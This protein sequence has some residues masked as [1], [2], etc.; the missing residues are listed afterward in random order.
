VVQLARRIFHSTGGG[1]KQIGDKIM[2]F[3]Y[4]GS[5]SEARTD[6]LVPLEDGR[7]CVEKFFLTGTADID[8]VLFEPD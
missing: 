5:W 1:D 2:V 7:Q 8:R 4:F 3:D 6:W